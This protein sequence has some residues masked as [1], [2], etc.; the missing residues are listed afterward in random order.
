MDTVTL[1][2]EEQ[3]IVLALRDPELKEKL[4]SVKESKN[5]Q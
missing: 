3:R 5:A 1:S 4:M 2:K